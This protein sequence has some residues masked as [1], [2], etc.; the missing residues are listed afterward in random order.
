MK[1]EK[2]IRVYM[3]KDLERAAYLR[4]KKVEFLRCEEREEKGKRIKYFVFADRGEIDK[5]LREYVN[6]TDRVSARQLFNSYKVFQ[7]ILKNDIR[8]NNNLSKEV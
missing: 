8:N 5:L 4:I 2:N 3:T 7:S 6:E 1:N